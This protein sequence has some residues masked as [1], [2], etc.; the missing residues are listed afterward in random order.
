MSRRQVAFVY[1]SQAMFEWFIVGLFL[2][3]WGLLLSVIVD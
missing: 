2:L 3:A 1:G